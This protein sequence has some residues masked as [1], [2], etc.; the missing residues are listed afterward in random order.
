MTSL[1]RRNRRTTLRRTIRRAT[2]ISLA[3]LGWAGTASAQAPA[4]TL[5][6]PAVT[7]WSN[8]PATPIAQTPTK[9]VE[10]SVPPAAAI[11]TR[12]LMTGQNGGGVVPVQTVAPPVPRG[13]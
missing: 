5:T 10:L 12:V 9:P 1:L 3:W 13:L 6:K 7:S 2:A 4:A 8:H 11:G